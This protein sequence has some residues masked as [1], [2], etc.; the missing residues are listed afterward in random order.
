MNFAKFFDGFLLAG[1]GI[2]YAV[3]NWKFWVVFFVVFLCFGTLMNLLAN[4]FSSFS[5]MGVVGFSG[6][7]KIIFQ[8]LIGTFGIGKNF[9]DFL[10]VFLVASLQGLLIAM[11]FLVARKKKKI[12]ND[13]IERAGIVTGLAILGTGCPT[14]GTALLT[15]IIGAI[16]AGGSAVVGAIS[17][18]ITIIAIGVAILSLR[19]VGEEYY[20][21]IES[22]KYNQKKAQ[23]KHEKG[24]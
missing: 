8:A 6:S 11:I 18:I 7:M 9:W 19:K 15:P 14:C 16:F 24:D 12:N 20:V 2:F 13:N 22:E 1:K 21:I 4:G 17:G 10:I 23:Q 5:L 3:R